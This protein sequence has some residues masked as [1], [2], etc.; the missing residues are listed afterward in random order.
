MINGMTKTYHSLL[1][2]DNDHQSTFS[3]TLLMAF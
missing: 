2:K 3:A 1:T